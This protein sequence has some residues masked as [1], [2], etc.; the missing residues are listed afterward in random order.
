MSSTQ[1]FIP[2]PAGNRIQS[3]SA[4]TGTTVHPRA[5]GEQHLAAV[6]LDSAVGSSPRLRGTVNGGG[7]LKVGQRFI[8]APAGNSNPLCA[9]A[10]QDPVHPRACGEQDKRPCFTGPCPGSSPRL[11]GTVS[12]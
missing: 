3:Q 8:P 5:C 7:Q 4:K 2:A 6:F 9:L 11:R 10:A 1:R 12:Q